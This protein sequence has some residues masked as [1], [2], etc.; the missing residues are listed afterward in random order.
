MQNAELK[1]FPDS[2]L[3]FIFLHSAFT[4][5]HCLTAFTI[6]HP[7]QLA[8]PDVTVLEAGC[9]PASPMAF[10]VVDFTRYMASSA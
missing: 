9:S 2:E 3:P 5:L 6:L 1:T 4:I 10:F 8:S 7:L